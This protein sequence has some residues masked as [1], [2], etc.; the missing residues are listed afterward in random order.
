MFSLCLALHDLAGWHAEGGA[1]GR[2]R[3]A[4]A[5]CLRHVPEPGANDPLRV[6]AELLL[7][8]QLEQLLQLLRNELDQLLK[9]LQLSGDDLKNLLKLLL[10]DS[11]HLLELLQLLRE[12]LQP[13]EQ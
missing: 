8:D 1:E 10:L 11:R 4:E 12:D 3:N 13:L 6:R 7:R 2:E 9:L 5:L